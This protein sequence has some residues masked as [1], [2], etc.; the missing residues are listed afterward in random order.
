MHRALRPLGFGLLLLIA[1]CQKELDEKPAADPLDDPWVNAI[2][3]GEPEPVAQVPADPPTTTAPVVAGTT[4]PATAPTPAPV[5]GASIPQAALAEAPTTSPIGSSS[6]GKSAPATASGSTA[7]N[8]AT[9]ATNPAAVA[10]APPEPTDPSVQPAAIEPAPAPA[11]TE[12]AKPA[13]PQPVTIADFNGNYRYSGGSAQRE[14]LA[15]AIEDAVLQLNVAIRGIGRKRLTNTNPIDDTLEIVVSGDK[16]QTIFETGFDAECTVDGGTVHW[17]SK[18]GDKYKV[19]VR[20][21]DTKI[22]QII[23]GED[24]VKTTVFVLSA[25]KQTLTVHHKIE[26]DRLDEPMTYKLSYKRK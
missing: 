14:A 17:T 26:A 1:A 8:S 10:P 23:E 20:K 22:V 6:T 4:A 15:A 19:R 9:E 13:T 3:D 11:A 5:D 2:D 25:D 21:K 24:G 16:V 18:K 7:T 12:P